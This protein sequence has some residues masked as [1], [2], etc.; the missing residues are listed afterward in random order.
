MNAPSQYRRNCLNAYGEQCEICGSPSDIIAHHIDGDRTNNAIENLVPV[1]RS[2]HGKIHSGSP[3]Y[4]EWY[5]QLCEQSRTRDKGPTTADL[6]ALTMY[7]PKD[8]VSD[9][10]LNFQRLKLEHQE[11]HGEKLE[12]NADYWP[13]V[14][15]AA[16]SEKTVRDVLGLND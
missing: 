3:G 5:D 1:C 9:E 7:L 8:L 2:C 12:K 11:E 6:T 13:A 16:H 4:E 15:E 10:D 14:F